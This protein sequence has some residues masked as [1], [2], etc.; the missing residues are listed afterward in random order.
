MKCLKRHYYHACD[1]LRSLKRA[2]RDILYA[3]G[4][5]AYG[6]RTVCVNLKFADEKSSVVSDIN[7]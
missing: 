4:I 3:L 2:S 1:G 6:M 7:L 5:L